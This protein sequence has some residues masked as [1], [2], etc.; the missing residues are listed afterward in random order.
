MTV[1][2]RRAYFDDIA[3]RWD[4]WDDLGALG[5]RLAAGLEELGV[6]AD[7]RVIDLGCGT[8]NLS[9]ALLER[10]GPSGRVI[11][12]DFSRRM[13]AAAAAKLRDARLTLLLADG[14][15][16]PLAGGSI[17]RIVCYS[18]WPHFTDHA[19][20]AREHARVLRPGGMLHVWHGASRHVINGI[21]ADAGGAVGG[22]VLPPAA[23]LAATI[24][25]AGFVVTGEIDGDRYLVSACRTEER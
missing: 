8:G 10:L 20:A 21:H 5:R 17:D 19:A 9:A 6:G 16:L 13:L 1:D 23:E 3:D 4:G 7:E 22:D 24:A 2:P 11:A 18:T 15:R 12:V 25:A 14:V